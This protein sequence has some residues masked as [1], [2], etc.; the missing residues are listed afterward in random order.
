MRAFVAA[1]MRYG[2]LFLAGDA[3]HIV[4]P[5]GAKGLNL[6]AADVRVL[7]RALDRVLPHRRDRRGSTA[8]PTPACKRVWKVMRYSNYMTSLLHRFETHT[9]FERRVQ[10]A[11]LDYVA[12]SARGAHHDRRELRRPAVRGGL[13]QAVAASHPAHAL[14]AGEVVMLRRVGVAGRRSRACHARICSPHMRRTIRRARSA[15]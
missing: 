13:T 11:E 8:I 7:S 4:P 14:P 10:Q 15:C 5:T 6:A 12:G 9:P 2:R 1:P 3:A